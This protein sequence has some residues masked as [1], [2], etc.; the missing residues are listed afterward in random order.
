MLKTFCLIYAHE[1]VEKSKLN[2]EEI[3]VPK[4]KHKS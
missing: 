1:G 3:T 4:F 2:S